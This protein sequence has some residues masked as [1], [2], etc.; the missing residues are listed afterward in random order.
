MKKI[1]ILCTIAFILL[2]G[3]GVLETNELNT[4]NKVHY[5]V[6]DPGGMG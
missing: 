2:N 1:A 6:S 4:S 3:L 5:L